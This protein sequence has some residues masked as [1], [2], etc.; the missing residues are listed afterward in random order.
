MG[1]GITFE[2]SDFLDGSKLPLACKLALNLVEVWRRPLLTG[3]SVLERGY[4]LLSDDERDRAS[5]FRV[6][7]ARSAFVL[8]RSALRL[9]L[10]GYL[11]ESPRQIRFRFTDH[12]KPFLDGRSDL[13][14]NVSH[15]DGLALL[16]FARK[17]RIGVDVERIRPQTDALKLARRFFSHSERAELEDLDAGELASGFFRCWSRK[18]AYI[19]A[20]GEGLSIPLHQFDMSTEPNPEQTLLATRPDRCEVQRWLVRDVPVPRGYAAAMAL[21]YGSE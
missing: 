3:A 19:K 6:E 7:S 20:R 12:G 11:E 4:E 5:R 1:Q 14:F 17:R 21:E 10:A 9:L 16:A 2:F 15:T 13:H 8:T 18:E